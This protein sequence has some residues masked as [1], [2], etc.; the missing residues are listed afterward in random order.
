[1]SGA[2][3]EWSH[4]TIPP[5][6]HERTVG[7]V[8]NQPVPTD[9]ELKRTLLEAARLQAQVLRWVTNLGPAVLAVALCVAIVFAGGWVADAVGR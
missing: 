7:G 1:M 5:A 9:D 2:G 3:A 4:L 6:R 8:T